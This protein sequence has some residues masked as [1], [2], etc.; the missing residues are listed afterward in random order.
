M[1]E[2][3]CLVTITERDRA[4]KF[5]RLF[6]EHGVHVNLCAL[7]RGTAAEEVLDYLGLEATEKAVLFSIVARM[8]VQTLLK[9]A[10]KRLWLDVPGNGIALTIPIS[11]VG[12]SLTMQYLTEGQPLGEGEKVEK[13][14]QHHVI[15]VITNQGYT[16][17]V[18]EAARQANAT[19]GT[20]IHAKGTGA[21]L[22][23]KFFGVSLATEKE[24]VFI[25]AKSETRREI[26]KAIMQHAGM[27]SKAQSVVFSLPVE[28]V[29]G[30]RMLEEQD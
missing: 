30:L 21:E 27:Q 25:V 29:A 14:P 4:E 19:G 1:Q 16:D 10:K 28:E 12:G 26:M 8:Q 7:G 24:M 20:V 11:S 13:Q 17:L 22:A 3:Q 9:D 23:Q 2:I 6:Q 15:I 18:M 5:L